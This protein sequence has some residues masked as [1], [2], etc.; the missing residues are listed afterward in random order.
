MNFDHAESGPGKQRFENAIEEYSL[1]FSE[2]CGSS[3]KDE[4]CP[5]VQNRKIEAKKN[6]TFIG[7]C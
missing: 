4:A 6:E 3:F 7:T 2:N 1:P 5:F